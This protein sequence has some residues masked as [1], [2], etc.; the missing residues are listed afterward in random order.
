MQ[1]KPDEGQR[2][3]PLLQLMHTDVKELP[4]EETRKI[5]LPR[6]Y[7]TTRIVNEIYE[8][9]I[10]VPFSGRRNSPTPVTNSTT[11]QADLSATVRI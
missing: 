4:E 11:I 7:R 10:I 8:L 9:E 2:C 3:A 6:V 5:L 1:P